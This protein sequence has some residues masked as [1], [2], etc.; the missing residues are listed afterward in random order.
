MRRA[1]VEVIEAAYRSAGS[2]SAWLQAIA[3]AMPARA[4]GLGILCDTYHIDETGHVAIDVVD[5]LDTPADLEPVMRLELPMMPPE[6]VKETWASLPCN[7][8]LMSGSPTTRAQT[9][10]SLERYLG[11]YGIRDIFVINGIDPTQHGVYIGTLLGAEATVSHRERSTWSRVAAHLAASY[12][13]RRIET[14]DPDAVITPAGRVEHAIDEAKAASAQQA[15]RNAALAI[16][17]ARTRASRLDE[18]DA[19]AMWHALV[20][21]RWTLV[22]HVDRDGRR[23]FVARKNDPEVARHHALTRRERQVIG[24]AAFGHSNKLIAYELGLSVSSV[25]AYLEIAMEKLGVATRAELI[26]AARAFGVDAR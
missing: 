17:R 4:H 22:D 9:R 2:T 18:G 3:A 12:R 19:V 11:P 5:Q 15:L 24:F 23:Y 25:A 8:A 16:D 20:N 14:A 7:T 21:G 6:Y 26:V 1:A 10:A 13:L